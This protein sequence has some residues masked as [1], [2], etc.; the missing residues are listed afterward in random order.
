MRVLENKS[1][2]H[3]FAVHINAKGEPF[4]QFLGVSSRSGVMADFRDVVAGAKRHKAVKTIFTHNH[5]SG[6]LTPS[7][8]DIKLTNKT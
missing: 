2:E 7:E 5:P 8:A 3:F 6:N 4:I 1:V